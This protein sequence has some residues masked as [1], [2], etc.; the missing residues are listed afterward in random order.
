MWRDFVSCGPAAPCVER[1]NALTVSNVLVVSEPVR[2]T[3]TPAMMRGKP[4]KRSFTRCMAQRQ[5]S[6]SIGQMPPSGAHRTIPPPHAGISSCPIPPC[7]IP[8][9]LIP[10]MPTSPCPCASC[11]PCQGRSLPGADRA[12]RWNTAQGNDHNTEMISL[13]FQTVP[14]GFETH[15][16]PTSFLQRS[17]RSMR[18]MSWGLPAD[19]RKE[20]KGP[21]HA[22]KG[23]PHLPEMATEA[24][25]PP[26]LDRGSTWGRIES[27]AKD[28]D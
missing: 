25:F 21:K 10:S 8:P 1:A 3:G 24:T 22:W 9:Y 11:L 15:V 17:N 13:H 2:V 20:E 26:I 5:G 18:N 23:S 4:F 6:D 16:V 14:T 12:T 28:M 7:P 27:H 19:K